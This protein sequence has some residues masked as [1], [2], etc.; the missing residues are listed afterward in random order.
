MRRALSSTK[1]GNVR[2]VV[3]HLHSTQ[4]R[5]L[6]GR[7]EGDDECSDHDA[8]EEALCIACFLALL[9]ACIIT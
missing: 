2:H 3:E 1:S 8:L 5:D 9:H 7:R 4:Q 6:N